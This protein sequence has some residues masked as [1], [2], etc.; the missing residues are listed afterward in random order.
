M[1]TKSEKYAWQTIGH[2]KQK[3]LLAV[4]LESNR[5]SHA[6]LFVGPENVGKTALALD[7]AKILICQGNKT[8]PCGE[9]QACKLP[10]GTNPDIALVEGDP[11]SVAQIRKLQD[12][13]ALKSFGA[14]RRVAVISGAHHMN[15]EAANALLKFLE[16]P[17]AS[18][19]IILTAPALALPE[20]VLSRVQKMFFSKAS[21]AELSKVFEENKLSKKTA[22]NLIAHSYGRIGLA[23][24]LAMDAEFREAW[25]QEEG[26]FDGLLRGALL[27]R[28]ELASDL[29]G[30]ETAE[31]KN[32]FYHWLLRA[33]SELASGKA[34]RA[35][36]ATALTRAL[37]D[38]DFNANKKLLLDNFVINL[39]EPI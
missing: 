13:F 16:E 31:L 39:P 24:R 20:T 34:E 8:K 12:D 15:S 1:S 27:K 26:I 30:Q 18:T 37:A 21:E 11:I 3:Q 28:M 29:A 23:Q 35:Q 25:E 38:L 36:V 32:L 14:G 6:Y 4:L 2:E 9:C 10:V 19:V 5:L 33:E 22:E 17:D 7:L